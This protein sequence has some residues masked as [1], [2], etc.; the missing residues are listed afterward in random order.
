MSIRTDIHPTAVIYP[1][2]FIEDGV[3]VMPYAVVGRPPKIA[4]SVHVE[5]HVSGETIIRTGA[6]IGAHAVIYAGTH[7]GESALIGDGATIRENCTID[8]QAIVGNNCTFQNNV[9]LGPR[10]RV[11]DLSHITAYVYIGADVFVSTGVLTMNDNSMAQGGTLEPPVIESG[12]RVGGGATLL[13]GVIVGREALV[14][15]G[16]VVTHNVRAGTR[17]QGVPAREYPGPKTDRQVWEEHFMDYEAERQ[18]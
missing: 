3:T 16:S 9:Y 6:V 13:P 15:A 5:P 2:V 1:G 12:A 18:T 7:V 17:V 11:I 10:S 14:A 4:G 8:R